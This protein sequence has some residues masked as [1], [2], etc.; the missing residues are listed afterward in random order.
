MTRIMTLPQY[1]W[2]TCWKGL[3]QRHF[4]ILIYRI[5]DITLATLAFTL[6]LLEGVPGVVAESVE[7]W[8]HVWEIFGSNPWSS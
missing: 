7:H 2:I 3:K 8:S 1:S 5:L 6:K 4:A